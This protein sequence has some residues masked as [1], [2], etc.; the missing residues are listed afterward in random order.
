MTPI[1]RIDQRITELTAEYSRAI[2]GKS[3][4]PPKAKTLAA[5]I[6]GLKAERDRIAAEER[7]SLGSLLPT[8]P[9]QRNEIFRQLIKLPIISDFLYGACVELQNTLRRHG[10]NEL[11]MTHRVAQISA[12]LKEFAFLLTN[13]PELEK[14][15]SDD[16]LLISALDKKVDSF[17]SQRMKISK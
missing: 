12:M 3:V 1:Q 5:K 7:H 4:L 15:L 16:D 9:K 17:L 13:F 14:I 10:L 11:T 8:D 2:A 6:A